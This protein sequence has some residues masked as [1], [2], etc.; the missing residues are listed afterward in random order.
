MG[1]R[2]YR[3][4]AHA[5]ENGKG[6]GIRG[7]NDARA[8]HRVAQMR[9]D[10]LQNVGAP[11]CIL[12]WRCILERADLYRLQLAPDGQICRCEE[13]VS[14]EGVLDGEVSQGGD[15]KEVWQS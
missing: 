1:G 9:S 5:F 14:E 13:G 6:E 12:C 7:S 4:E 3:R 2:K 8:E 10:T 15:R 11:S